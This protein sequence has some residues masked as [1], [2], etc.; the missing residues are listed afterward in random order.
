MPQSRVEEGSSNRASLLVRDQL[1]P[2]NTVASARAPLPTPQTSTPT[3]ISPSRPFSL[4]LPQHSAALESPALESPAPPSSPQ[5][6][7]LESPA[8]RRPRVPNPRRDLARGS[9]GRR[10]PSPRVER[11]LEELAELAAGRRPQPSCLQAPSREAAV[12][13]VHSRDGGRPPLLSPPSPCSSGR[14]SCPLPP[15]APAGLAT[16]GLRRAPGGLRRAPGGLQ[17]AAGGLRA[18]SWQPPGSDELVAEHH[19]RHD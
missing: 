13:D 8:Q 11:R 19:R 12:P 7:A 2:Q 6:A 5:E 9:P 10:S 16:S 15:R 17:R 1:I 14:L 4:S 3:V 18:S